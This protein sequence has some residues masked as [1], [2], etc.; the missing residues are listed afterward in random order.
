MLTLEFLGD[1]D[2]YKKVFDIKMFRKNKNKY[3][4]FL[5]SKK[6][7]TLDKELIIFL[8]QQGFKYSLS[9]YYFA[10]KFILYRK[11]RLVM[12]KLHLLIC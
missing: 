3:L 2:K 11:K 9:V 7:L 10:I 5:L 1:L 12:K 4:G 6:K 8:K